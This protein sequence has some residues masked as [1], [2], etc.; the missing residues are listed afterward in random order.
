MIPKI[1]VQIKPDVFIPK[2]AFRLILAFL[3]IGNHVFYEIVK[4]TV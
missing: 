1:D 4:G 2:L 3:T